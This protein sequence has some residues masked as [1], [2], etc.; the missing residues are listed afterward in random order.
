MARQPQCGSGLRFANAAPS[1]M[2]SPKR[3]IH[4]AGELSETDLRPFRHKPLHGEDPACRKPAARIV[5]EYADFF[6]AIALLSLEQTATSELMSCKCYVQL[7]PC[8][9][10][11]NCAAG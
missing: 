4:I 11:R 10:D 2:I 6:R 1:E 8:R 9:L 7:T 3:V 5:S